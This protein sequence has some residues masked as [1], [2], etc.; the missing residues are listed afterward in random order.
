MSVNQSITTPIPRSRYI[1]HRTHPSHHRAS[2]N[3]L[4]TS[5]I[6]I[7][8]ATYDTLC[9]KVTSEH[10]HSTY[11]EQKTV[12]VSLLARITSGFSA[13]RTF[14]ATSGGHMTTMTSGLQLQHGFPIINRPHR[15]TTYV[16]A[17]Y[18]YRPS[19]VVSVG[20][21]AGLSH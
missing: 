2:F 4:K 14:L 11:F 6:Y 3:Q 19:S 7:L 20:L 16:D 18:C 1:H 10:G 12:S 13:S 8:Q 5:L 15:S 21:S 9:G 17:A